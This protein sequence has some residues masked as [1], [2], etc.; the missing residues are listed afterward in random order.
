[1]TYASSNDIHGG[2][3]TSST[4]APLSVSMFRSQT[5]VNLKLPTMR[6]H[7]ARDPVASPSCPENRNARW[8]TFLASD[9][10]AEFTKNLDPTIAVDPSP[11]FAATEPLRGRSVRR[12]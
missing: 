2:L 3:T 5:N 12:P 10:G 9:D 4:A 7:E 11:G 1:M 6:L 8:I